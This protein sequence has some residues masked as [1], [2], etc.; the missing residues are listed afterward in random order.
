MCCED[1]FAELLVQKRVT[2]V[3]WKRLHPFVCTEVASHSEQPRVGRQWHI[4]GSKE[5]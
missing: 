2:M 5:I 4:P 1:V 3:G